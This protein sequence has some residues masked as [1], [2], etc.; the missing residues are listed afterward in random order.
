M[1]RAERERVQ[2]LQA[3]SSTA[4][5]SNAIA[6][7]RST[8]PA[9]PSAISVIGATARQAAGEREQ[10]DF[11]RNAERPQR[12]DRGA[13]EPLRAPV[14]R[15]EAVIDRVARLGKTRRRHHGEERRLP[16][17]AVAP[18]GVRARRC[19]KPHQHQRRHCHRAVGRDDRPDQMHRRER[20]RRRHQFRSRSRRG[21]RRNNRRLGRN[22][23]TNP[24]HSSG[25]LG[26]VGRRRHHH[27]DL[28]G[29]LGLGDG[30]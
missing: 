4:G 19:G 16:Q 2:D 3:G 24:G 23:Y 11:G 14:E 9:A 15:R 30:G 13:A 27:F 1:R 10:H 29:D 21:S 26:P 7:Q 17:M 25:T 5:G 8:P 22:R 28:R 20:Y 6:V 18:M 12:A